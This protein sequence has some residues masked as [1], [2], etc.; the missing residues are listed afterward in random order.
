MNVSFCFWESNSPLAK[1][2]NKLERTLSYLLPEESFQYSMYL[3]RNAFFK[4][5]NFLEWL[6]TTTKADLL[7]DGKV[8]NNIIKGVA[9]LDYFSES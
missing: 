6:E 7:S 9:F 5:V 8:K 3:V 2:E 4:T 1:E